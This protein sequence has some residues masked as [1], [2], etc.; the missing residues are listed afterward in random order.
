MPN[1]Q[2][3]FPSEIEDLAAP[4]LA[5]CLIKYL[6]ED[7]RHP[8]RTYAS[9]QEM[10]HRKWLTRI[11]GRDRIEEAGAAM[12]EAF[13]WL[14]RNGL[15]ALVPYGLVE[16]MSHFQLTESGRSLQ[17]EADVKDYERRI[18]CRKDI[19]HKRIQD[20]SWDSYVSGDF[21]T[22]VFAAFKEI[23]VAVRE[24]ESCRIQTSGRI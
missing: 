23:E 21:A 2:K 6:Q 8:P 16:T 12:M 4:Q 19:L 15:I 22:S 11:T 24:Q 10:G 14:E 5:F 17:T 13:G 1:P 18:A 3:F 9:K 7:E 20:K